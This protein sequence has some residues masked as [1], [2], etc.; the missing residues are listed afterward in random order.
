MFLKIK[1]SY[2]LFHIP[3]TLIS[4]FIYN[5]LVKHRWEKYD[6]QCLRTNIKL[7]F[8]I[9]K[10]IYSFTNLPYDIKKNNYTCHYIKYAIH[11]NY[12][13]S[14]HND[15]CKITILIYLNKNPSI[16]ESFYVENKKDNETSLVNENYWS[17]NN[18][19][20][21]CLVMWSTNNSGPEHH[22]EIMGNGNRELLCL[23]LN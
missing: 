5:D 18:N 12:K 11:K 13:I 20:Y 14:R 7:P 17:E 22:G 1:M 2:L 21:G 3:K 19:T 10:S 8:N 9:I 23:F 4:P 16:Q 6:A 15:G